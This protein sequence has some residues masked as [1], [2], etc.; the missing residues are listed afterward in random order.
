MQA[1]LG[2]VSCM[3]GDAGALPEFEVMTLMSLD[4]TAFLVYISG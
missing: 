3:S 1:K 4:H 2:G